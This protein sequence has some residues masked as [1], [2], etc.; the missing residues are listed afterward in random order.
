MVIVKCTEWNLLTVLNVYKHDARII[1]EN[2]FSS[3]L[4]LS[5]FQKKIFFLKEAVHHRRENF[6]IVCIYLFSVKSISA[7]HFKDVV[8]LYCS[9][10]TS[11]G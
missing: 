3:L 1:V 11:H 9:R 5:F 4:F 2:R 6:V 10:S 7:I 8:Q